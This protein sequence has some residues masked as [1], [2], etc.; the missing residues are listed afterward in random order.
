MHISHWKKKHHPSEV[1]GDEF[2]NSAVVSS[3]QGPDKKRIVMKNN[4]KKHFKK[5]YDS[6]KKLIGISMNPREKSL[7][8]AMMQKDDWENVGGF[9]KYKLFG[10]DYK[11]KYK[12]AIEEADEVLL[13]KI[14]INLM[15]DMNDQIDY[16][17]A[18]F[19]KELEDLKRTTKMIDA[20]AISK[21]VSLLKHWNE[22][23]ENK[24]DLLFNDCQLLLKRMDIVVERKQ[25]DYL[26]SLPDSVLEEYGRNWDDTTS[27]EVL[28]H[29]RRM[30]EK[31][32]NK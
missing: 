30:H 19:T 27:P 23:I 13:Q 11:K 24:T 1:R 21:W 6:K 4:D 8:D 7:L 29:V 14:L 17:N 26:R 10:F 16:I 12:K 18:R 2:R 3:W 32:D 22:S 9:I 31:Y 5:L 25:Q 20:K 28:E 15:S